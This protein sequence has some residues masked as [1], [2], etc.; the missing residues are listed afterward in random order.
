[1]KSERKPLVIS[2]SRRTDIPCYYTSWLLERLREQYVLVRQVRDYHRIR[3]IDLS[4]ESVACIV[5]WTK[6]PV[7][8]MEHL[9]ILKPY[10]Y[11]VHYTITGYGFDIEPRI[12]PFT[13]S[14]DHFR[15]FADAIGPDRL[16]WR[17][18]P[19]LFTKQYPLSYHEEIFGR[20]ATAL[21]GYTH[22]CVFSF[23]D[24]YRHIEQHLDAL[25][26][27]REDPFTIDRIARHIAQETARHNMKAFTCAEPYDLSQYGIAP[28]A[29]IDAELVERISGLAVDNQKDRNQRPE[30]R[31]MQSVD[32]GMYNTCLNLCAYCYA[33]YDEK[34]VHAQY[35]KARSTSPL[36]IGALEPHD[37]IESED[38][39]VKE[40][41]LSLFGQ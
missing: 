16:I 23:V 39:V 37:T 2:A 27:V 19:I 36:Q 41:Q 7:P 20:I 14:I 1:M 18:D 33:N 6:H 3:K 13:E 31:C 15:R 34:L 30:C 40:P 22:R 25:Q 29:C 9:D 28:G 24:R 17:Y 38:A 26:V 5:F 21:D 8:L 35:A 4:V 12:V 11:Y 32:I 10:P